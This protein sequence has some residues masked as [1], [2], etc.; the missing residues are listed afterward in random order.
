M[1]VAQTDIYIADVRIIGVKST[2]NLHYLHYFIIS[3]YLHF[4]A[5]LCIYS[6]LETK[7][8]Q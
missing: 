5:L 7:W 1:C 4:P 6:F 2:K 3:P 8:W